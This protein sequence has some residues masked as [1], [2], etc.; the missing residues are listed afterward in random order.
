MSDA[1]SPACRSVEIP[2]TRYVWPV[3]GRRQEI[4]MSKVQAIPA[5]MTAVTPHLVCRDAAAAISFYKQAFGAVE[6]ARLPGPDG[7]LMHAQIDIGGAAVML[8]DEFPNQGAHSPQALNGSPVTLHLY[9]ADVDATVA[10]AVAAGARITMPVADMFWGDRYGR[11][12]DPFG[13]QW[14]VATHIRDVGPQ[15]IAAAM[16][17]ACPES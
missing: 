5:G 12:E 10:Q 13:H 16:S 1:Y 7:L 17:K 11:L 2:L 6:R 3:S 4:A 9:V 14:S 15:E 8:V